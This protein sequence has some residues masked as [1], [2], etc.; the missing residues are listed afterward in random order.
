MVEISSLVSWCINRFKHIC[1]VYILCSCDPYSCSNCPHLWP[2][3][4]SSSWFLSPFD[5]ILSGLCFVLF[6]F[7][8]EMESHS[9]AQAGMQ[10][11]DTALLQPLLLG[12]KQ[13]SCLSLLSSWDY[14][15]ELPHPAN[16]C[17]FSRDEG[18]PW[19]PGWSRTPD[20]VICP[21]QPPKVLVLQAWATEAGCFA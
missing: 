2:V 16:F 15:R 18:S 20:L 1:C 7:V 8:F 9:V 3:G 14:R 5:T 19:W 11:H 4:T 13:F 17:I 6:C 21:P 12:L 10:W